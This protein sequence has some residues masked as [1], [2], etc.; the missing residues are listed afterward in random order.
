MHK[1]GSL[2]TN[3]RYILNAR[4]FGITAQISDST[5]L[6]KQIRKQNMNPQNEKKISKVDATS[7]QFFPSDLNTKI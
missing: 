3:E 2:S 4:T 1:K 6:R 7:E 5:K